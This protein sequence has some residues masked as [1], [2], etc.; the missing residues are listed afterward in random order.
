MGMVKRLLEDYVQA[1][2]PHDFDE[3]D[4]LMEDICN[5]NIVVPLEAM[6]AT[7][8]EYKKHSMQAEYDNGEC[9]DCGEPIP[10]YTDDGDN[11]TNCEHV[12]YRYRENDDAVP[13][14]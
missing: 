13:S 6:S 1:V 7:V 5:G 9:P 12:F 14:E 10:D 8:D 11:C 4:A 2:H 3:Q